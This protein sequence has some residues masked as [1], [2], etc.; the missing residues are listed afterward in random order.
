MYRYRL[1]APGPTP[2]PDSVLLKMAQPIIHHR[3][4]AFEKIVEKVREGLKWLYQTE[5]EVLM[6]A[7]SGTGAMEA[8]VV[9]LMRKGDRALCI[10]GGKF[11]ERWADICQAYGIE[12]DV[13][14][15]E[16]GSAVDPKVVEAKLK[17]KQYRTVFTTASETSTGVLHPIEELAKLTRDL[18]ETAL[19]VDGITALGVTDIP[20]DKWGID[21]LVS[22]SQKALM[23]PPGLSFASLSK[24]AIAFSEKSDLPKFY[25]DF[26]Q[27]LK[28]IQQNTTAWTPAVSLIVGL[29]EVLRL[30]KEE[31]LE[32]IFKRHDIL[33]K[34]TRAAVQ[35]MSLK[36]YAPEAPSPAVTAVYSPENINAGEIV[37]GLR[38]QFNMTITGGQAQ[39]KGKIF[40]IGHI[41]YYD[42]MDIVNA[43]AA[44]ESILIQKGHDVKA[45]L[46]VG[47]ALEVISKN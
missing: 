5:N 33:A 43:I 31:G 13:I 6:F 44:I 2:V 11:G 40:R 32:N 4:A 27:E 37:K 28:S 8:S 12:Y 16:W 42:P 10:D 25:F 36:L 15:V 24:K 46:G 38:D 30:M 14:K 18:P 29:E 9:N 34:A 23:L 41:G 45:G 7:S 39:A 20:T 35:A 21:V 47:A 22:G 19:V 1:M 3:T 17:E 26:R